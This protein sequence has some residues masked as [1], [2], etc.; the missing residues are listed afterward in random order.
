MRIK[1]ALFIVAFC[2]VT[3]SFS[4]SQL[5][6]AEKYLEKRGELVFTF[7]ANN[8]TEANELSRILSFVR[9]KDSSNPLKI[10]AYGNKK[11]FSKFLE[12]NLPFEVDIKANE[13]KDVIMFD[14]KV[15]KKN[16]KGKSNAYTL[17]FPLST[18][19]TYAQYAQQMQDFANDHSDIAELVDIGGTVQ[20]DKRL[21]FIKLSDSISKREAEPRVMY[22]ATMHGDELAGY[23]GMLN[24]I[25]YLI[26]A[27][28]NTGHSDHTR[29][30]NLLDSTEVWINP[31]ANPDAS[32]WMS[33]DN[34]SVT[35]SRRENANNVDLNRNYPDNV[36]G[37][38]PDGNAYQT[39]TL[40]FMQFA[41][42]YH[43]VISANLHGGIEL[44]NYPFDNAYASTTQYHSEDP[45]NAG[46]YY[47]HP[48]TD[49]FEYVSVEYATQAQNDSPS[50]Y[51]TVDPDSY[52]YLSPGVTHG[53]EWYRVYGGRQ[54]YMNFYHQTR[55]VTLEISDVKTPPAT[56]TSSNDEVIDL[57]N[58][59]QEAYIKYLIQGTY[60]FRGIVKDASTGDILDAKISI[61]GRDDQ[62]PPV[63]NSWVET[64][65]L[66][67]GTETGLGDFY[68][69]I[70]AGTYD[71]LI[72]ANGD[73]YAP[74][75][76]TNQT[77][78]NGS[79]VDLGDILL[80]KVTDSSPSTAATSSIT[81]TTATL[82]WD[83]VNGAT[84]Y[85]IQYRVQGSSTWTSDTSAS[86][87]LSLTGLTASTTYEFQVNVTCDSSTSAYSSADT[88]TTLAVSYCTSSSTDN[89]VSG[90]TNVLFNTIDYSDSTNTN[91]FEDFT[92]TSTD[93]NIGDT[94]SL[95]IKGT[96]EGGAPNPTYFRVFI[97]FNRD[98]DFDDSGETLD[99]G[100]LSRNQT[101][102]LTNSSP[103]SIDIPLTAS[104]GVTRMRVSSRKN[105]IP[106]SC[107]SFIQE[108]EVE[109]YTINI[110]DASLGI[111]DEL[112]SQ[113]E[114]YPNPTDG[115]VNLTL[116]QEIIDFKVAVSSMLGQEVYSEEIKLYESNKHSFKLS[117]IKS[118][119]YF[120]TISTDLGKATKK[121]IIK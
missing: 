67:N 21:L 29:I 37:A 3:L 74:T 91:G 90:I 9:T 18:Y 45:S 108:G 114:I 85:G 98:G 15:H 30:K 93:V 51:M 57:W 69:P 11:N 95:S 20:G 35:N 64:E 103:Y 79:T 84:S 107:G 41:A 106:T 60:G 61:V 50:G 76:L 52:I 12:Y 112:L 26:T 120:I 71:I 33:S 83:S 13:P 70:E 96:T 59:N 87:S 47:T 94:Y 36:G 116:P 78:T 43:F 115:Q 39:E 121:I 63:T 42:D 86:N 53:A 88:F 7:T 4:Q 22:T 73:C 75:T 14:P 101:N 81:S 65:I 16:V 44:V 97:D 82:N 55:E 10:R 100:T 99:L 1:L 6:L 118:G 27:Y 89:G 68:R 92:S 72:E 48:D 38:N 58:Y 19:P 109:D 117:N 40:A 31:L 113:F 104:L 119:I 66:F 5:E 49:W 105:V 32:F 56:N 24:L 28:K 80:Q 23:P 17:S 8:F 62:A 34:T 46:P 25:D 77:I 2:T 111:Q 102:T 110:I 54:D